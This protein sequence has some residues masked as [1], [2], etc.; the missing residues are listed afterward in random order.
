MD[1][2]RSRNN[3][4]WNG[5][6]NKQAN[7]NTWNRDDGP[8]R[9]IEYVREGL[10]V[11]VHLQLPVGSSS[12]AQ[13]RPE[14]HAAGDVLRGAFY[15]LAIGARAELV[16]RCPVVGNAARGLPSFCTDNS[17]NP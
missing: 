3:N 12:P 8:A 11:R 5:T 9:A 14:P 16:A 15:A 6:E 13:S 4:A 2:G 17:F 7:E 1:T 10:E